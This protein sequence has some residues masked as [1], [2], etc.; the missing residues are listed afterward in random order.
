M[1]TMWHTFLHITMYNNKKKEKCVDLFSQVFYISHFAV[2]VLH[3]IRTWSNF[4]A[5]N[6]RNYAKKYTS[7]THRQ[8]KNI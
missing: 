4:H 6:Q 2:H 7:K 1:L 3:K 5:T 8:Q